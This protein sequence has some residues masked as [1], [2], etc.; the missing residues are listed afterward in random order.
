MPIQTI[1]SKAQLDNNIRKSEIWR[2]LKNHTSFSTFV[3]GVDKISLTSKNGSEVT[4]EWFITIE[5]APFTW[6]EV[7]SFDEPDFI[8]HFEAVCG[9][10]EKWY[11]EWKVV[12]TYQGSFA[13]EY[14]LNYHLGIPV[15]EDIVGSILHSKIQLFID[16]M[17]NAHA[18][19]LQLNSTETR[20]CKRIRLNKNVEFIA[21][22][23]TKLIECTLSHYSA[24]N[25]FSP[26][27]FTSLFS[28][29]DVDR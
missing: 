27:L 26:S 25:K 12:S 21:Q 13:L 2:Q 29:K 11:G 19:N 8:A 10:F 9:D 23:R 7:I 28:H 14:T 22:G 18:T 17:V 16:T 5:G 4:A 20:N 24:L 1:T 15:I 6:L 3:P